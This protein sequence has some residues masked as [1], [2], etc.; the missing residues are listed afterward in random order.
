MIKL[1]GLGLVSGR[2][3][4][5]LDEGNRCHRFLLLG[6][7][8]IPIRVGRLFHNRTTTWLIG[9]NMILLLGDINS[10]RFCP[11]PFQEGCNTWISRLVI[12]S[13]RTGI[14]VQRLDLQLVGF[15]T[16]G[17]LLIHSLILNLRNKAIRN[18]LT[19]PVLPDA[20]ASGQL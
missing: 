20:G 1:A 13:G 5:T 7:R 17:H 14:F 12:V 18:R 2:S 11:Q 16:S 19:F 4:K 9:S 8:L 3:N 6:R 15:L 10:L